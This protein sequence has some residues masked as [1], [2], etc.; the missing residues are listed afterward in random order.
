MAIT[1]TSSAA[2]S[3]L[4]IARALAPKIRARAD[5]IEA[6]RQLPYDLVLDIAH[7][8]LFKVGLSRDEGGLG[9]D[10]MTTLRV[11]EEIARAD[12]SAG[13][14]VAMGANTFRQSAQFAPEVRRKIF[15]SDP[16]GVSAG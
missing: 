9:A 6:G 3:P 1:E 14:C 2:T 4:D 10:I 11:I 7:A 5:E 16:I 15:H 12:G 8:G 13:W